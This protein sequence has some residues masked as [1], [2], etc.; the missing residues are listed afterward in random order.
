[1]VQAGEVGGALDETLVRLADTLEAG[2]RLRSKVKSA[3]AYPV[4]VLS[5][6][7]FI[8]MAMLLFIVPI[9]SKMYAELGG[10]L[11]LPTKTLVNLSSLLGKFWWLIGLVIGGEHRGAQA[12]DPHPG[13]PGEVGPLQA[14]GAHLRQA[15]AEGGHQPLCPNDV[16][17]EP[18]RGAGAPGARH[19]LG[20]RRAT[21]W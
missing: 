7:V 11:P 9:F 6:I 5:L 4:V 20:H 19:R 2:V 21:P 18:H 8:V 17:A 13:R 16:G 12:L 1:M 15:G 3:M 14:A 10:E